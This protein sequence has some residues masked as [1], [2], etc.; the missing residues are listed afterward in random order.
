MELALQINKEFHY[1]AGYHNVLNLI[2]SID[3]QNNCFIETHC[4]STLENVT[5][6]LKDRNT[7]IANNYWIVNTVKQKTAHT[8]KC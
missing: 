2:S 8:N 7:K 5:S 1:F 3:P 6:L 4:E